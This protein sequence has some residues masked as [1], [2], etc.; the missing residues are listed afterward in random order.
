MIRALGNR[1]FSKIAALVILTGAVVL[2]AST[3]V[4]AA[5]ETLEAM[6]AQKTLLA[7]LVVPDE[8]P[9]DGTPLVILVLWMGIYPVPFLETITV[10]VSNL[11]ENYNA[12]LAAAGYQI[13][14][15]ENR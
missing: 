6:S 7:D 11:L 9:A 14:R 12:A 1:Y 4:S 8:A 13:V 3:P 2:P 10:S 5:V 15:M